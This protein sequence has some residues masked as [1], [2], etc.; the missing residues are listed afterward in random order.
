MT[1]MHVMESL[2][3]VRKVPAMSDV[4]VNLKCSLKIIYLRVV[5]GYQTRQVFSL[6]INK[7]RDFS[8]SFDSAKGGSTPS[9]SS[10][11]LDVE[12]THI[13]WTGRWP[14][15][16]LKSELKSKHHDLVGMSRTHGRVQISCPAAAT[17]IMVDTP[18]PLWHASRA[19]R[20]T[21]TYKINI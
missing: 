4:F 13:F 10:Y 19:A 17:P 14:P 9:S 6:T 1:Y 18:H 12:F 15:Y 21:C 3:Y 8:P 2:I 7:T 16:K 5:S 11:L 20:I